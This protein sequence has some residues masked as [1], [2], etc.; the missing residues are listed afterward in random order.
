MPRRS[1]SPHHNRCDGL[2]ASDARAVCPNIAPGMCETPPTPQL[3]N[4]DAAPG[5]VL[6]P[7]A[8]GLQQNQLAFLMLQVLTDDA[9]AGYPPLDIDEVAWH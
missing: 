3:P 2:A 9:V 5:T 7:V 1:R 4:T 8:R 6:L